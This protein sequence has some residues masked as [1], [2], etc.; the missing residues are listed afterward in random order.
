MTLAFLIWQ[1]LALFSLSL[2]TS[3]AYNFSSYECEV[4]RAWLDST[5]ISVVILDQYPP[6]SLR[7][8]GIYYP[9]VT[10]KRGRKTLFVG[11]A[12]ILFLE[13]CKIVDWN[14]VLW[15][16]YCH[17]RQFLRFLTFEDWLEALRSGC[18]FRK[19]EEEARRYGVKRKRKEVIQVD[20]TRKREREE[21]KL[22]FH[23][24]EDTSDADL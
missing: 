17:H 3:E 9:R 6:Y 21:V 5:K 16:Q 24:M 2:P 10:L 13:S 20:Y 1:I 11:P 8:C 18:L 12:A 7:H 19:F 14:I 4:S 15:A 23:G 22:I